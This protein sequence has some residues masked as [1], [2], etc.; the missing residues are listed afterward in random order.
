MEPKQLDRVSLILVDT[1]NYAQAILSLTKSLNQIAPARTIFFT[2]VDLPVLDDR[3]EVIKIE[4]IKSKEAYSTFIVKELYKYIET[5]FVLITQ[6]DAVVLNGQSWRDEYYDYDLMAAP[7][8]YSDGRNIGN[9]GG[10]LRSKRLMTILGTDP[11]IEMTHPEDEILGRLYRGYLEK[12][13]DI[14]FP[15]EELADTFSY[16]LRAPACETFMHH[17][18]FHKPFRG[19][20]VIKRTGAMGDVIMVE[21]V[22][23]YFHRKGF[24]VA[25]DTLPQFFGLFANHYFKVHHPEEIDPRVMATARII[26]LDMGYEITPRQLHLKSYFEVCGIQDGVIRNPKLRL[27][28][29]HKDPMAKMFEKYVVLH[30]D[31]RPQMGRNSYGI[32]WCRI[33]WALQDMGYQVIQIG[34]GDREIVEEA[35]QMVNIGEMMLMRLIGAADLFVG[36]DSGPANIA[37]AMETPAVIL[38][39]SVN[40]DYIIP[41]Q[42]NVVAITKHR[43]K[44]PV[45]KSPYCWS[46][47]IGQEGIEC[48]ELEGKRRIN[49]QMMQGKE[50]A[51]VPDTHIPPCVMF[52]DE[53]VLDAI[54]KITNEES[55]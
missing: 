41:D 52:S 36:H 53:M 47:V 35:I 19:V 21:P 7:W 17:S 20:V 44:P 39:G 2:D 14:K 37:I 46:S 15:S 16:E 28:Y 38:F 3:V 32:N 22:M 48:I 9:G 30:L 10:S 8:L 54:K 51:E 55:D 49:V 26:N 24:R 29:D 50:C 40:P 43:A 25:L 23:E 6:W 31:K 12:K 33:A 27:P 11:F 4:P 34:Q 13:Y 45:C 18:F 42:S 1:V 5:E